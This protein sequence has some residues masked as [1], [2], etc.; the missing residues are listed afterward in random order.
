VLPLLKTLLEPLRKPEWIGSLA[1]LIQAGILALQ[2]KILHRHSVT[3]KE[4]AGI[5]QAQATTAELIGKAL[6]Q[7]GKILD[8]Q[9]QIMAAQSKFH[10]MTVAHTQREK[11]Y[12]DMLDLRTK[13]MMLISAIEAPGRRDPERLSS[14]KLQWD[15]IISAVLP[16]QKAV[17][18]CLHLLPEERDYFARYLSDVADLQPTND[19]MTDLKKMK[20]LDVKY[21]DFL[22]MAAKI[23]RP[24][25]S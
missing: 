6:V 23:T 12:D 10:R 17:I 21:Q 1:L 2:A 9:T 5:S 22:V 16:C 19:L 3:M 4:H 14:E 18:T 7:Q 11:V 20:Q 8:E 25:E 15:R 13:V 24:P